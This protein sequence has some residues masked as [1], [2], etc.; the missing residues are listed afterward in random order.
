VPPAEAKV[1]GAG[2][3]SDAVARGLWIRE[4]AEAVEA[5]LL[6]VADVD[7]IVHSVTYGSTAEVTTY[8]AGAVAD[9]QRRRASRGR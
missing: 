3:V 2:I 7:H 4:V 1:D 9:T 8:A 5:S 6:G